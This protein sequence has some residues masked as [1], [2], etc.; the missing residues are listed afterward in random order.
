MAKTTKTTTAIINPLIRSP[1]LL[2]SSGI[3]R[4]P[5]PRQVLGPAGEVSEY[6][7]WHKLF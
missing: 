1:P 4:G 2:E 6:P 5:E 7:L 3:K